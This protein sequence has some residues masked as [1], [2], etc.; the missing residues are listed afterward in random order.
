MAG[1][2]VKKNVRRRKNEET[3]WFPIALIILII[4]AIVTVRGYQL[5]TQKKGFSP[6]LIIDVSDPATSFC[7]SNSGELVVVKDNFGEE[8]IICK[9]PSGLAYD[10]D[11][12]YQKHLDEKTEI[13]TISEVKEQEPQRIGLGSPASYYCVDQGGIIDIRIDDIG[14][15]YGICILPD[16]TE[17]EEWDFFRQR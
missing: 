5:M 1:K 6:S 11:D 14:A 2:K 10:K 4:V 9:L 3:K 13:D 16:G 17:I 7:L 12:Y 8:Y 15:Q